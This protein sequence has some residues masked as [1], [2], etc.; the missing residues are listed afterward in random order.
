[1]PF[2][3][4][5]VRSLRFDSVCRWNGSCGRHGRKVG[6]GKCPQDGVV[7]DTAAQIELRRGPLRVCLFLAFMQVHA[8]IA[9]HALDPHP[10]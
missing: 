4:L 10:E 6:A 5:R 7:W 9:G 2:L 8:D 1:M 3:I